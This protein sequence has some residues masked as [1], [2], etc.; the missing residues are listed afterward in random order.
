M[1]VVGISSLIVGILMIVQWL[2]FL[3][4]GN[5]PELETAPVSITF[6]IVIE[7]VT[8]LL[9]LAVFVLLVR[10]Q[11]WKKLFAAY[12][13]GMLGYTV[14]NSSGYFA[15]SGQVLFLFMFA[16]LLSVSLM[17]LILIIKD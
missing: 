13:Q 17:N 5:V 9:L 15:Q 7:I 10:P 1:K 3:V 12:V 11:P 6:H 16:L 2:F 14:V 8:A 4:S